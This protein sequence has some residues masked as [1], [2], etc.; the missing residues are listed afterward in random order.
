MKSRSKVADLDLAE[1]APR[2]IGLA[3]LA[4]SG[5]STVAS[6]LDD[7]GYA[8]ARF[9]APLKDMLAAVLRRAGMTSQEAGRCVD[10]DMKETPLPQLCG[11]TPRRAMQTL[12]TEW[13]RDCMGADLWVGLAMAPIPQ[14]LAEGGR[15]V[16][17]DVRFPNEAAAIRAAGGEVWQVKGR[18][19]RLAP[20]GE[21]HRSE[22][23]DVAPDRVLDNSGDLER[24][25]A[26]VLEA[27]LG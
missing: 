17:D 6:L 15:V 19:A 9:A 21:F 13:G 20:D 5:K 1:N 2:V 10:G 26:Q 27:I 3:G 7:R 8:H 12:G 16:F 22:R 18:A 24:L 11:N 14:Y 4:G 23:L 25:E